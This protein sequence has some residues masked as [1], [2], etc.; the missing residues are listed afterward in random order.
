MEDL[1][2]LLKR[3]LYVSVKQSSVPKRGSVGSVSM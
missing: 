3:Y 1:Q 2:N